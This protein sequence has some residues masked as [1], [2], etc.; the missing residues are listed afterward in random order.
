MFTRELKIINLGM[1]QQKHLAKTLNEHLHE[2]PSVYQQHESPGELPL[3]QLQDEIFF[4]G[5]KN[6]LSSWVPGFLAAATLTVRG[7]ESW[8]LGGIFSP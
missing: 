7:S 6:P 4:W 2:S 8:K 3:K 1:V 5:G